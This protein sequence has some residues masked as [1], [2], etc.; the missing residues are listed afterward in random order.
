MLQL[1]SR[2]RE[3]AVWDSGRH[4]IPNIE[5]LFFFCRVVRGAMIIY[6]S[7]CAIFTFYLTEG[8]SFYDFSKSNSQLAIVK[9]N[10]PLDNL[11]R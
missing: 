5:L 7:V 4:N 8:I 10:N 9:L 3:K 2:Y 11:R 6:L 1:A